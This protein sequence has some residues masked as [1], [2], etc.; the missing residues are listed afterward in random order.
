MPVTHRTLRTPRTLGTVLG[1]A[2]AVAVAGCAAHGSRYS[3]AQAQHSLARLETPGLVIGEFHITKIIDG[4]TFR[5]NGLDRS[6]RLLAIDT[7]E[8]FKHDSERRAFDAGWEPYMKAMRGD[9]PR[10]AKY[11][12]PL[13]MDAKAWAEKFFDDVDRVRL[14]RDDPREIRGRYNRYLTYVFA[15]KHG[16]WVNYNVECVRAGM[17]PYFTK[18]GR[19]RR[20]DAD[21]RKAEAEAKAAHRGIW[22]PGT[23]HYPDYPEREAWW[24]ARA[25]F[26]DE[27]R[28][29]SQ[30]KPSYI[31]IDA[32]DAVQRLEAM[33]GQ[34]V[35]V[36]GTV[37]DV[38]I[39]Q[40][41]P[42]KVTLA[43]QLHNDFPLVFFDQDVLGSSGIMQW[44]GEYV[45]VTG[46]PT[47]Y[48]N[49]HTHKK[50]L[51][52]VI[53]RPSQ[54]RLSPVPGLKI[55]TVPVAP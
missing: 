7:E 18:Y 49:R 51:Q 20:F 54:I 9:R 37:A 14:E 3:R 13:G 38:R 12:T 41:G 36:L 23:M 44:R 33:A 35:V 1:L 28:K 31:S 8:T 45:T 53:D 11:A 21:F 19:S 10:P 4:D 52:I 55:P 26:I 43:R 5:V 47:L 30:G 16:T 27:F 39:G 2:L 32:W 29:T 50:Q 17:A 46:V 42:S 22:A 48:E 24:N 34:Q 6:L 40:K 15:L 25:D